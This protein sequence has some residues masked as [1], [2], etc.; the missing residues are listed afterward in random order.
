MGSKSASLAASSLLMTRTRALGSAWS[1]VAAAAVPSA[2]P[3]GSA[4]AAPSAA[5]LL[6]S[7]RD[8]LG[9]IAPPACHGAGFFTTATGAAAG[10]S[11]SSALLSLA[12]SI[13]FA[14][15]FTRSASLSPSTDL[16]RACSRIAATSPSSL[17]A[18][19]AS[20]GR[21]CGEAPALAQRDGSL[22]DT[23]G[24]AG[25]AAGRGD[26][27]PTRRGGPFGDGR[28]DFAPESSRDAVADVADAGGE[29]SAG[30]PLADSRFDGDALVS[31]TGDS[32]PSVGGSSAGSV[33]GSG[34]R[35]PS[36]PGALVIL[37]ES[38]SLHP[39]A[40]ERSPPTAAV[41][42]RRSAIAALACGRGKSSN[43]AAAS[44]G[45]SDADR[46]LR[47]ENAIP[48]ISIAA[49]P[50]LSD[51]ATCESGLRPAT[52]GG[53]E[54]CIFPSGDTRS[55]RGA[56]ALRAERCFGVRA[57]VAILGD[58]DARAAERP[59]TWTPSRFASRACALGDAA[60]E[61]RKG[62]RLPWRLDGLDFG[63]HCEEREAFVVRVVTDSRGARGVFFAGDRSR[64][65]T[66]AAR[67]TGASTAGAEVPASA[68]GFVHWHAREA[69]VLFRSVEFSRL[70][71]LAPRT[72]RLAPIEGD[73]LFVFF[74][75][76][77]APLVMRPAL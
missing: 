44:S 67:G 40:S 39:S 48:P 5:R 28:F 58:V 20:A 27:L 70:K 53:G 13:L 76:R 9:V 72:S 43:A 36:A 25:G 71:R 29:A 6:A 32:S 75:T 52:T 23:C 11:L 10:T 4:L 47:G 77:N 50:L 68:G 64:N 8:L 19:V 46:S 66:A 15:G 34:G 22:Q 37:G 17:S 69:V 61:R 16:G 30:E 55:A 3:F 57:P 12:C 33:C 26:A 54:D 65:V 18:L 38:P 51:A 74:T 45:D 42:S 1:T 63:V 21:F 73:L 59:P 62:I 31:I 60:A 14:T 24:A 49:F 41:D 56:S 2:A 35:A 7:L